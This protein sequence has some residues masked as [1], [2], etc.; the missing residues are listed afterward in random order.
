MSLGFCRPHWP[1]TRHQLEIHESPGTS[2]TLYLPKC[3]THAWI[4]G[5]CRTEEEAREEFQR[6]HVEGVE[7]E[8]DP[9]HWAR[10]T[11]GRATV[12]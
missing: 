1:T 8:G 6:R 4:G 7:P 9:E 3:L 12:G 5:D 10:A 11:E 2:S